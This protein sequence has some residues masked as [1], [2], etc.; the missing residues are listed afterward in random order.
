MSEPLDF[1]RSYFIDGQAGNI[2][3]NDRFLA[4]HMADDSD[5]RATSIAGKP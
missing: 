4:E 3:M 2:V 5:F 1:R